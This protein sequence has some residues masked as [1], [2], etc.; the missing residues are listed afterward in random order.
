MLFRVKWKEEDE[1]KT[2]Y[3]VEDFAQNAKEIVDNFYRQNLTTHLPPDWHVAEAEDKSA[4]ASATA[5][6][7]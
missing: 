2:W 4:A 6:I 3:P 1:D 5:A 7:G